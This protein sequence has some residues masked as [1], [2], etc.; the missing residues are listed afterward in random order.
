ME[1]IEK[2][3]EEDPEFYERFSDRLNKV[4]K[5]YR[6]SWKL[7]AKE[8]EKIR[9]GLK[10]GRKSEETFGFDP[11]KEMPFLGL[12][13]REIFGKVSIDTLGEEDVDFLLDLTRDILEIIKREI[14][15]V[16]FW[17]NYT[18]QKRLR[19]Y[20]ISHFLSSINRNKNRKAGGLVVRENS[21]PYLSTRKGLL[22]KRT[23][24]AQKLLELAYHIYGSK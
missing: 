3:F 18:K 11:K 15:S 1:Y 12:L 14:R 21:V 9:N 16:D 23:E 6:E 20:L 10:E 17:R 24:I 5:E 8:L 19:A 7:L 2:H 4:L 13:K 22:S